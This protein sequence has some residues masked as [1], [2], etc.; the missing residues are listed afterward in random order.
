MKWSNRTRMAA[1]VLACG[2]CVAFGPQRVFSAEDEL[3]ELR[4]AGPSTAGPT[5]ASGMKIYIDP[6]TGAI[7]KEPPPGSISVPLTP[8]MQNALSSSDQDLVEVPSPVPG[9]GVKVDLQGRFQNP[10]F[11]T[12][13]ADGKVKVLHLPGTP[14]A[15]GDK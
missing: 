2:L 13:D 15:P 4:S 8:E 5:G 3:C 12:T 7:L 14:E 6:Q 11:A 1:S 10:V 9:G